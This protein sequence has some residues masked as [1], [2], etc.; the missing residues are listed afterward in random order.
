MTNRAIFDRIWWQKRHI[1]ETFL[2]VRNTMRLNVTYLM[3][4]HKNLRPSRP[5]G[6]SPIEDRGFSFFLIFFPAS[7]IM[8]KNKTYGS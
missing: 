4:V 6:R 3:F 1:R 2:L 7:D 8:K 5:D